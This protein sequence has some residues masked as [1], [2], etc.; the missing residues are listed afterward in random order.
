MKMLL[1]NL[2]WMIV[3]VG[4]TNTW[5]SA[6]EVLSIYYRNGI[7]PIS[8]DLIVALEVSKD[9]NG[10][11][12]SILK[13]IASSFCESEKLDFKAEF[14]KAEKVWRLCFL[15]QIADSDDDVK[16]KLRQIENLWVRF[17][18]PREWESFIY[19]MPTETLARKGEEYVYE[20]FLSFLKNESKNWED[21]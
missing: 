6:D 9:D 14:G 11:F 5:I 7:E 15:K 16:V 21:Y 18:Y 13:E 3:Y 1:D 12:L 10:H 8:D 17:G 20:N 4:F 2:S 19:Y